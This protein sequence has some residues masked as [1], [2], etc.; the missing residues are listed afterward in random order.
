MARADACLGEDQH[1]GDQVL[2]HSEGS[3]RHS[4]R[5]ETKQPLDQS[6]GQQFRGYQ[7]LQ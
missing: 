3:A 7:L 1:H 2:R 5:H 4:I 6:H